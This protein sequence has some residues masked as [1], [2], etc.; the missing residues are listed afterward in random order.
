ML[1][2]GSPDALLPESTS[3]PDNK[4]THTK[5]MD[6]EEVSFTAMRARLRELPSNTV[7]R[8]PGNS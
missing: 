5:K 4:S 1:Q 8:V 3:E 7:K 6:V 2:P